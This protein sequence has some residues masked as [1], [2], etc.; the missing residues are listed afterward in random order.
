M[1]GGVIQVGR[2]HYTGGVLKRKG[3]WITLGAFGAVAT[4]FVILCFTLFG[5]KTVK[6][7]F[8]TSTSILTGQA[9][10][11]VKS[12]K[13]SYNGS[14]LF[15]GKK[16]S[17]SRIEKAFPYIKVINIE[18]KFPST[19]VI[20]AIERNE[21][22]AFEYENGYVITDDEFKVLDMK[23]SFDSTQSNPILLKGLDVAQPKLGE[24]LQGKIIDVYSAFVENNFLLHEQKS[25]IKTMEFG[26]LHDEVINA[27]QE[28]VKFSLFDGQT[29]LIKNAR[30]GL[31][32]KLA[33]MLAVYS[34]IFS[35]IGQPIDKTQPDGEK[36]TAEIIRNSV[37]EINN[38]YRGDLH[39]ENECY[40]VVIPP[41]K[42][43]NV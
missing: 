23:E 10:E 11:I 29:Y 22:Y 25:L 8:R 14:V 15:M 6:V 4:V 2:R 39:G 43:E 9:E 30:Y 12:G 37:I 32:Y 21:V 24:K 13:F 41:A 36:W 1:G 17:I 5:L 7:D 42:A 18:T 3:L 31:K 16:K 28:Y 40:F 27:D 20:H 19:Y 35:I 38:Y 33:K 26:V 34:N